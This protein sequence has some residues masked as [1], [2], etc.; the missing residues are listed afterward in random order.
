MIDMRSVVRFAISAFATA[1]GSASVAVFNVTVCAFSL[2]ARPR[3]VVPSFFTTTVV[4]YFGVDLLVGEEDRAQHIAARQAIGDAG[5]IGGVAGTGR[6]EAMALRAG[7]AED[8]LAIGEAGCAAAADERTRRTAA[9]E[10]EVVVAL[11][12]I[13]RHARAPSAPSCSTAARGF[14]AAISAAVSSV[15]GAN[16][17]AAL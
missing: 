14:G 3:T 7:V 15:I 17:G 5:Q 6:T 13:E 4:T 10:H 9:R 2:T 12:T 16:S 8:T 11:L 1:T